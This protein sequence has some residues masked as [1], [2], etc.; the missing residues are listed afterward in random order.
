VDGR[1]SVMGTGRVASSSPVLEIPTR[2][3][4]VS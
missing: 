2:Q 4:E 1:R 3:S